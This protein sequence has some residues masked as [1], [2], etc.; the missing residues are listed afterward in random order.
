MSEQPESPGIPEWDVLGIPENNE[1][2]PPDAGHGEEDD[3]TK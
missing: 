3:S 2:E 1:A